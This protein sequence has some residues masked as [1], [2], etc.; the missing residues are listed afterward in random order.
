MASKIEVDPETGCWLWTGS[1]NGEGQSGYGQVSYEG[2]T[3]LVHRVVFRLL[4]GEIPEGFQVRHAD[5]WGRHFTLCCKPDHLEAVPKKEALRRRDW[6]SARARRT[7]C[8]HGHAY[9][10]E[11]SYLDEGSGSAG[12]AA[13]RGS[14]ATGFPGLCEIS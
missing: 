3:Q 9:T 13:P 5:P 14:G 12:R 1:C 6:E 11:N 2:K 10:P 8:P 4:V 7:H